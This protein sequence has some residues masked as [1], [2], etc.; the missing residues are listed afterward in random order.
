MDPLIV[1][2]D[3]RLMGSRHT[4][5]A[6]YW[7]GLVRGLAGIDHQARIYLCSNQ[8]RPANVPED[9]RLIWT[10]VPGQGRL[11]SLWHFPQAAKKLGAQVVHTQYSLSPL[12]RRGG[13]TTIHDVS[14]FIG[15]EWFQPRDRFLL[16]RTLPATVRRAARVI[17]VSETSKAE[18]EHYI[19]AARGKVRVTPN[20]LGTNI[21][22]FAPDEV[23][24]R[25]AHLGVSRPYVLTVGT[26]WPRKNMGLAIAAARQAGV[27]CVVTGQP[28]WGE[29]P[30]GAV[31]TGYVDDADL[32]ALYQGASLYLAPSHHEGFGIPLLEAF[33]CDCPVVANRGGALPEVGG[34][35]A[36]YPEAATPEA[37]AAT[38]RDLLAD[39]GRL[40]QMRHR[41][42]ARLAQ[43]DW[44]ETARLTL[45]V[46][47]EAR[48]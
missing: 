44:N 9:P 40:E 32:T 16:Q 31:I 14:F 47:E 38:I 17:T 6:S 34:D 19:P 3:A 18:I 33:A 28:G 7:N 2:I 5:D 12:V 10:H 24:A 45:E 21:T 11:W 23:E 46:Y 41:G 29:L 42:R 15:P 35:A 1:A 27:T 37:W 36:A 30:E 39:S 48:R 22:P 25:L 8:P 13:V 26:R 4:G 43:Y 20:A